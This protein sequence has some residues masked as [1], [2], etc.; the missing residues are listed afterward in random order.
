MPLYKIYKSCE[1]D[2][3]SN[4]S[5]ADMS[6]RLNPQDPNEKKMPI[7][8]GGLRPEPETEEPKKLSDLKPGVTT[9]R[10]LNV[11]SML[12]PQPDNFTTGVSK[13]D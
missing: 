1:L 8:K 5:E 4:E 12:N 3:T 7:V 2:N 13:D 6:F 9:R 10:S 11:G